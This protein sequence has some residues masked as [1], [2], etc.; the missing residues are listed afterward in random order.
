MITARDLRT[1]STREL[2]HH[3]VCGHPIDPR[4]LEGWAYRGTS[5]GLPGFV[6]RLTWKTFQK[7]F[8]RETETGR[9]LGWNV[10]LE[11]DGIDAPSRPKTRRGRPVTEWHYEVVEPTGVPLPAGFDG[12]LLI[13]YSLGRNPLGLVRLVKDPLVALRAGSADELLGVSYLGI[14]RSAIETPTYFTLEREHPIDWVPYTEPGTLPADPLRLTP[15]ERS[16]AE[17][18]FAAIVP[19]GTADGLPAFESV[20]PVVFWRTFE[21]APAPLVRAGLRP[22]VHTLTF[23]PVAW[24]FGRPFFALSGRERERF[25]ARAAGSRSYFVRQSVMTLK[26]LACFAYFDDAAVRGRYDAVPAPGVGT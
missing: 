2:R 3:L 18:L 9:L 14:G 13:D 7:T 19:T 5:L 23:L 21:R 12:G 8:W 20:D 26:L 22:M 4:D 10:R 6:D 1:A 11:Q 16:W 17:A 15:L 24:G 25:I